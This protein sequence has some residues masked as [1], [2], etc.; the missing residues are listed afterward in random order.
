[1]NNNINPEID[2][3]HILPRVQ[4]PGRYTGGEFGIVHDPVPGDLLTGICFPDLYEIGMSNTAVKLLYSQ[5]NK[6]QNVH[7][8]RVFAPAP[9]FESLLEQAD[10]PLYTLESGIPLDKLDVLGF[11]VGYELSATNILTVL[12]RGHIPIKREARRNSDPII[13]GGG[14]ALTNPAPFSDFFDAI[15]IGEAEEALEAIISVIKN[16]RQKGAQRNDILHELQ[17]IKAVWM[18]EKQE[19]AHRVLWQGFDTPRTDMIPVPNISV[20][21]DHGVIEIMRGCANGCRFC[22]AGYFYRPYRQKPF[23]AIIKEADFYV[24]ELGYREITLSSLSSGDYVNLHELVN[25]LNARYEGLGVSFALPSLRVNSFT[26]PLLQEV[27]KIRKSGLTFAVETPKKEWQHS[28]NKE[29]TAEKVVEILLEAR[30]RGWNL[31][32]FYFMVG[33]PEHLYEDE[34]EVEAIIE[35]LQKVRNITKFKLNVNIGTFIPKPHTPYQWSRQLTEYQALERIKQIRE[36]FN[37]SPVR[38]NYHSPFI[39]FLEGVISRGDRRVGNLI[40]N[41]YS[42]GARLDAWEEHISFDTWKAA[43]EDQEWNVE[44]ETCKEKEIDDSLPWE[45]VDIGV[46]KEYLKSEL[47]NSKRHELTNQ[48]VF[49]CDHHCGVCIRSIRPVNADSILPDEIKTPNKVGVSEQEQK[50]KADGFW[51]LFSFTKQGKARFLSHIN[52][53]TIFERAFQRAGIKLEYTSGYNP[54][55]RMEFAHPLTLGISSQAEIARCKLTSELNEESILAKMDKVMPEGISITKVGHIPGQKG[56]GRGQSLMA[57]Y[58]ASIYS[59]REINMSEKQGS[60]KSLEALI[61][62]FIKN[63]KGSKNWLQKINHLDLDHDTETKLRLYVPAQGSA[64]FSVK[65]L[66][67][68]TNDGIG[69]FLSKFHIEREVL[70][71]EPPENYKE[72][73]GRLFDYFRLIVK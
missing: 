31:A 38:V 45:K 25:I 15:Y 68:Y 32:K 57:L 56:R 19:T 11:S 70:L 60:I 30:K 43:I 48:C 65:D 69:E 54:K 47:E 52:I 42:R 62:G 17:L 63:K 33:L 40:E 21:Q 22:H 39:S 41:A 6:M 13:I 28:L 34:D 29:V 46:N 66:C 44:H 64:K 3:A 10:I 7:C 37:K 8:E 72:Q 73:P 58:S 53:M 16:G 26:L 20:V 35:Y 9:D 18:P 1:M 2:L 24:H 71:M 5:L 61:L 55:P 23:D 27:S 4:M 36:A 67:A 49:P 14:P 50:T 12:D 51:Y 59:I